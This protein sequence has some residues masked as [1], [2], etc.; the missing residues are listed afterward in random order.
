[1]KHLL[2]LIVLAGFLSAATY[3]T[4]YAQFDIG[5]RIGANISNYHFNTT[6]TNTTTSA[7]TGILGGLQVD[8]WFNNMWA[9]SG[10]LLYVQKGANFTSVATDSMTQS[11]TGTVTTNYLEIPLTAKLRFGDDGTVRVYLTAGPTIGFL[12]SANSALS[13]GTSTDVKSQFSSTDFGILGGVGLDILVTNSMTIFAEASYRYGFANIDASSNANDAVNTEN[14][15][16]I[17]ISAGIVWT[18]SK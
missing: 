8:Y 3:S 15:R 14:T 7:S 13:G 5:A 12:L 9:F 16:D 2:S 11:S 10:Q 18:L 6:L 17:R 4:T 1:M